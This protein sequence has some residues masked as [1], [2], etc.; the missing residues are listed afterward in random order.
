MPLIGREE[1]LEFLLRRWRQAASGE[2]RVVLLT[3]EPGIGKSRLLVELEAR[4]ATRL[5]HEFA[6]FLLASAPG[7]C[8]SSDHRALGAGR[9]LQ[10]RRHPGSAIA[11]A[12]SRFLLPDELSPTDVVLLAGMLGVP[13]DER[14]PKPD[15][16][17]Q[18]RKDRTFDV[19]RRRLASLANRQPGTDAVR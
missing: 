19:L 3:G 1:E 4:L 9:R 11:K 13:T 17:S 16:S 2:G 6:L 15:L 7:Q 14:Y 12:G 5:P 8:A 18:Q 10:A